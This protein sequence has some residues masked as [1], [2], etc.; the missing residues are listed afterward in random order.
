M[1]AFALRLVLPREVNPHFLLN[2]YV[3]LFLFN[4]LPFSRINRN[5]FSVKKRKIVGNV[6]KVCTRKYSHIGI[7]RNSAYIQV[8]AAPK[9][10]WG[11]LNFI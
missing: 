3:D 11:P 2:E 7:L 6:F 4:R 1:V 10:V 8:G 5:L 9:R